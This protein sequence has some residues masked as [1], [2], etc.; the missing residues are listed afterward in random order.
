MMQHL[1]C[2]FGVFLKCI[3]AL[4]GAWLT[5]YAYAQFLLCKGAHLAWTELFSAHG[6]AL[7]LAK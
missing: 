6:A 4:K 1:A 7:F 3:Y 2:C 5:V